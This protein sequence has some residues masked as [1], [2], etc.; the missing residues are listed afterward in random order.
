MVVLDQTSADGSNKKAG[1]GVRPKPAFR[2]ATRRVTMSSRRKDYAVTSMQ[3][4]QT[5]AV[6]WVPTTRLGRLQPCG[7]S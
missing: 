6:F 3:T 2:S 7:W 4:L 1:F 5:V